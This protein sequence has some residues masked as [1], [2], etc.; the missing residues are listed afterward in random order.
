VDSHTVGMDCLNVGHCVA[1]A[2]RG[3]E[4]AAD[5]YAAARAVGLSSDD[6]LDEL[7]QAAEDERMSCR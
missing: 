4:T 6:L 7:Q 2:L 1:N 3:A 5:A